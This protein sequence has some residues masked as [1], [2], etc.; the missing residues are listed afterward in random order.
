ML[1]IDLGHASASLIWLLSTTKTSC[2][3][4]RCRRCHVH[5][6]GLQLLA[7][8]IYTSTRTKLLSWTIRIRINRELLL[9]LDRM[10]M[11]LLTH[12]AV[13]RFLIAWFQQLLALVHRHE[14]L[15]RNVNS[16]LRIC[17]SAFGHEAA[18]YS[19]RLRLDE[20][21]WVV[22]VFLIRTRHNPF[23]NTFPSSFTC[24]IHSLFTI[25]R[26]RLQMCKLVLTIW[27]LAKPI[28]LAHFLLVLLITG[29]TNNLL[30]AIALIKIIV[31]ATL[32]NIHD[33]LLIWF[34]MFICQVLQIL[35]LE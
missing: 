3:R 25:L 21:V 22:F 1:H 26:H 24:L 29:W 5:L 34:I 23:E 32:V 27:S 6:G 13:P 20:S 15:I 11:Q 35:L 16:I 9:D 33:D 19:Y 2:A 31:I 8:L 30:L 18:E 14:L 17:T 7:W 4:T 10:S 28:L 12:W